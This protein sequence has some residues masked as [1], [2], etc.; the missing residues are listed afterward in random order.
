MK[1]LVEQLTD[2]EYFDVIRYIQDELNLDLKYYQGDR[3][4]YI[5]IVFNSYSYK[6]K[7]LDDS[8]TELKKVVV[9]SFD[10]LVDVFSKMFEWLD[11]VL[12]GKDE[13]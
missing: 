6:V 9:G 7:D 1:K 2:D 13:N 3:D 4:E 11:K 10:F 5:M 12:G 8:W